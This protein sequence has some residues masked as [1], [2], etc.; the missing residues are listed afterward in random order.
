MKTKCKMWQGAMHHSGYGVINYKGNMWM[1]HRY[2]WAIVHGKELPEGIVLGHECN[3]KACVNVEH[4]YATTSQENSAHA[5]RDGLYRTGEKHPRSKLTE[6]DVRSIR[7][8]ASPNFNA[9][10][11][12]Y[13][14][15]SK[16]I[17]NVWHKRTWRNLG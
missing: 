14:V 9:I 13:G 17:W 15:D 8:I 4:L 16:T 10:A 12:R 1:A 2:Q 11:R 7:T 5:A 3:N 6:D